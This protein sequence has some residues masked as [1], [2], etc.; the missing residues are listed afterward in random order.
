MNMNYKHLFFDMDKTIAPARE[1]MLPEMYELLTTLPQDIIIVSGSLLSQIEFQS[2]KLPAYYLGV[3]GNH[4]N[5]IANDELWNHPPLTD[6][7]KRQIQDHI[8]KII[9]LLDHDLNHEWESN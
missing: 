9:N 5:N 7:H 8:A 3:N 1:P 6:D 2:H 4:A